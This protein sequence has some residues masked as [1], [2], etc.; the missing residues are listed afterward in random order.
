MEKAADDRERRIDGQVA[1][2]GREQKR[3]KPACLFWQQGSHD[4]RHDK[5]CGTTM[6]KPRNKYG[7]LMIIFGS[8]IAIVAVLQ[9]FILPATIVSTSRLASNPMLSATTYEY[10]STGSQPQ[11]TIQ[12]AQNPVESCAICFFGLPR[13]FKLLVLP[14]VVKNVLISNRQNQ[15]DFFLHY[16]QVE[17]EKGGRSGHG[18]TIDPSQVWLLKRAVQE[19]YNHSATVIA[20]ITYDSEESFWE[21]RGSL[22]QK[23]RTAKGTDGNYLYFPWKAK[24]FTYPT[25]ID[26]IVK[27]WHSIDAVW[28]DMIRAETRLNRKYTRVAML[29]NDVV[30]V[31]PFNIYEIATSTFDYE[32]NYAIVPNWARFPINDRMIYGPRNAVRIWATER[33]QRLDD[34][35]QTYER[36][37]GMHSERFLNHSIFPAIREKGFKVIANPDICFFRAR[38]DGSAWISD[39]STRD[40]AANGFRKMSDVEKGRLVESIVG[41]PCRLSKY[42]AA[43]SQVHCG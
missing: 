19:V 32:N 13:S 4:P 20:S 35:V 10:K 42:S 22:L 43:V 5:K 11:R 28:S 1:S 36:G 6:S 16:Y 31:T 23:Y 18:G 24:S 7:L 40:G 27:Q 29:R 26:N 12:E 3:L 38:A 34:H 21:K 8:S 25:S 15:C 17:Q 33:F 37:Y 9:L 2:C 39:C 14:S 30:Y 41:L